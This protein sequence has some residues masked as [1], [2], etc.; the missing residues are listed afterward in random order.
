MDLSD[1]ALISL[2]GDELKSTTKARGNRYWSAVEIRSERWFQVETC[3]ESDESNPVKSVLANNFETVMALVR[4]FSGNRWTVIRIYTRLPMRAVG[5]FVFETINEVFEVE[6][7]YYYLLSSGLM[8]QDNQN[9]KT[10]AK[11]SH[12]SDA[13]SVYR[14]NPLIHR[15]SLPER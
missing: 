5:G 13:R 2:V 8:L 15:W 6:G 9:E 14:I 1:V 7:K 12:L 3:T 11:L 4:R 10:N